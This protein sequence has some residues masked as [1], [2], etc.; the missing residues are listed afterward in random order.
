MTS[1]VVEAEI[2]PAPE[3]VRTF[4]AKRVESAS[5]ADVTEEALGLRSNYI[6]LG[7]VTETS[8]N[9]ALHVAI[10]TVSGCDLIISWNFRHIVHFDKIPRYNAVN[11]LNGYSQVGIY[12][13]LEV[14]H[15][16]N[17]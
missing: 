16:D 2:E 12:S 14:I 11:V 10:A 3:N 6:Q 8:L 17:A 1:A 13:P 7:V 5:I 15:Y 9:D 4:F